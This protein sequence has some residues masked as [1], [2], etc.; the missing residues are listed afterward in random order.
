MKFLNNNYNNLK[1]CN[2][3]VRNIPYQIK[4]NELYHNFE[5]F[6]EIRSVRIAK[7]SKEIIENG[8]TILVEFPEG[9]G[10]VSFYNPESA[11]IA[12]E[13]M[14]GGYLKK[15]ENW[16]YSLIVDY[17][18]P[19]KERIQLLN[20]NKQFYQGSFPTNP[21]TLLNQPGFAGFKNFMPMQNFPPNFN[22]PNQMQPMYNPGI[23]PTPIN[24]IRS[25]FNQNIDQR[26]YAQPA[27]IYQNNA[28]NL[29]IP[30][31]IPKNEEQPDIN[32]LN[33]LEDDFGKKDYLGEFIFK[34]IENHPVSLKNNFT[35]DNIGKITGMIL[36][37]DDIKEITE[38]AKNRN[39]LNTR[40]TEAM[41]LMDFN[42]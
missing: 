16:K 24:N 10:Y 28:K 13:K 42:N 36:G 6:G 29:I 12:I 22:F 25:N 40:L 8:K 31:Q 23:M 1:F 33:S 27:Q 15:Y 35:I 18:M 41:E 4:E 19:K 5:Q 11:K 14:N 21:N 26:P 38:I 30:V 2:L 39:L 3:H 34:Q 32:Y 37:I 17:F 20:K 7:K 9:F